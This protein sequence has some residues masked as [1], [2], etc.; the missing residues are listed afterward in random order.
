[1]WA[2]IATLQDPVYQLSLKG[3]LLYF[4]T[5]IAVGFVDTRDNS[6]TVS[7]VCGG[8]QMVTNSAA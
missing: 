7:V 1:M 2:V 8:M 3:T 5:D 4:T 6:V